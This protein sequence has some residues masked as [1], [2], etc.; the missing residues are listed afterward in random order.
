MAQI[1]LYGSRH[2]QT[3]IMSGSVITGNKVIYNT[4]TISMHGKTRSRHSRLKMS[5]YKD[6]NT[7]YVEP[8]LDW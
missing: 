4:G 3:E 1:T 2:E 8:E 6:H 7:A 5:V